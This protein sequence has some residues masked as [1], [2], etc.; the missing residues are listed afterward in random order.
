MLID[1]QKAEIIYGP[2]KGRVGNIVSTPYLLNYY[3]KLRV[4]VNVP[5]TEEEII[6]DNRWDREESLERL[7][8]GYGPRTWIN[9]W[10]WQVHRH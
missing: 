7:K 6:A 8:G 9:C 5:M 10:G 1:P 2:N 4:Q 3:N